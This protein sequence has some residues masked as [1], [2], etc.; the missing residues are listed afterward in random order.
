VPQGP[1]VR[2]RARPVASAQIAKVEGSKLIVQV[3]RCRFRPLL[4]L[5]AEELQ[6]NGAHSSLERLG[7]A[8]VATLDLRQ[9][10]PTDFG[11]ED[12]I[13][14]GHSHPDISPHR[15]FL[16]IPLGTPPLSVPRLEAANEGRLQDCRF[17]G[18]ELRG[19]RM[20]ALRGD[21]RLLPLEFPERLPRPGRRERLF[22]LQTLGRGS[23]RFQK[24][25]PAPTG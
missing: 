25:N 18:G 24:R 2:P 12:E 13:G 23:P 19:Q 10:L 16:D 14:H 15:R 8:G 4:F 22:G 6:A 7:K 21:G 3:C 17:R 20:A 5:Q 11:V 1:I 9:K